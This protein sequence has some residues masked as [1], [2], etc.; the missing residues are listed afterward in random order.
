MNDDGDK[1]YYM[2]EKT[3]RYL[4][5]LEIEE[6]KIKLYKAF[7]NKGGGVYF[8]QTLMLVTVLFLINCTENHRIY[9]CALPRIPLLHCML[10]LF[11][12]T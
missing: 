10:L 9:Q 7:L 12:K 3:A 2:L 8:L 5:S 4:I 11:L 1:F 6:I